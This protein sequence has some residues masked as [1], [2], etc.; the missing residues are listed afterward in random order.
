MRLHYVRKTT[1]ISML[2]IVVSII[3]AFVIAVF[4]FEYRYA[5]LSSDIH[6]YIRYYDRYSLYYY[7]YSLTVIDF[8]R[9]EIVFHFIYENISNILGGPKLALQYISFWSA[10]VISITVLLKKNNY[11]SFV[12]TMLLLTHPRILNLLSSQQRM[13]FAISIFLLLYSDNKKYIFKYIGIMT[14]TIHTFMAVIWAFI[15]GQKYIYELLLIG[16]NK[17]EISIYYL[18]W[19]VMLAFMLIS[20]QEVMLTLIGDRR[21]DV[22]SQTI[23]IYY[24]I[25]WIGTLTVIVVL[26]PKVVNNVM[27]MLFVF[28][29]AL[30]IFSTLYGYYSERYIAL[31]YIFLSFMPFDITRN[32]KIIIL[33][34]IVVN[35][36]LSMYYYIR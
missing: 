29:G 4:V 10:L 14:A 25:M 19:I 31:A 6:N 17:R 16:K 2:I 21:I 33:C 11:Y 20:L 22:A 1:I 36:T 30:A 18:I 7:E 28:C 9:S 27:G 15:I 23:G 26:Y 13:A 8:I 35:Y 24:T 12:I 32:R 3:Y 5:L 34:I